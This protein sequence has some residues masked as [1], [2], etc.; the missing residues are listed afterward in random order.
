MRLFKFSILSKVSG[1]ICRTVVGYRPSSQ[2]LSSGLLEFGNWMSRKT[3]L[4]QILGLF[5]LFGKAVFRMAPKLK[6]FLV[7]SCLIE[8]V[9]SGLA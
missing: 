6:T 1:R 7:L 8:L 3:F 4:E 9:F 2:G 5:G